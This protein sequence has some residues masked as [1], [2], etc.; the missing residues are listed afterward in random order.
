MLLAVCNETRTRQGV[1]HVDNQ[2]FINTRIFY[3]DLVSRS[4]SFLLV[5]QNCIEVL[6]K[7]VTRRS[8][9]R[10][11]FSSALRAK[12]ISFHGGVIRY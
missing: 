10:A 11:F 2:R 1:G 5:S 7:L 9:R 6:I 12:R 8:T 3:H 4:M